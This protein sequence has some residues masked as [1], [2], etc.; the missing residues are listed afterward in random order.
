MRHEE[1][2]QQIELLELS[3]EWRGS[4][5]LCAGAVFS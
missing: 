3:S 4:V 2:S 1:F 5:R